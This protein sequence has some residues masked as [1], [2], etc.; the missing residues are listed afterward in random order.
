MLIVTGLVGILLFLGIGQFQM[1]FTIRS[2]FWAIVMAGVMLPYYILSIK[3]LSI[4]SLAIY[5]MYMML[6]GMLVPFFYGVLFLHEELSWGKI[7]GTIL[8]TLSI[9]LQ[10]YTQK[11][12]AESKN[13]NKTLFTVLCLLIFFIN[14]MTGVVCKA[15]Q[16]HS[17]AIDEISF[18]VLYC[19]LI[20]I[21]SLFL[22]LIRVFTK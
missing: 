1:Q 19:S 4:G 6:G 12:D 3:I 15:H 14:G 22:L 16:I 5:S 8:L 7:V 17:T 9:V 2:F 13:K 10:S 21:F 20:V 18:T 11:E